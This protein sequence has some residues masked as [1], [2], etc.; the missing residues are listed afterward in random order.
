MK[1]LYKLSKY[2]NQ[3]KEKKTT[4][5]WHSNTT[6]IPIVIGALGMVKKGNDTQIKKLLENQSI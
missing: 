4:I 3:V 2:K 6:I 5:M 1:D